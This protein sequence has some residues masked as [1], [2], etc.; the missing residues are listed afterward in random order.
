MIIPGAEASFVFGGGQTEVP[1][2]RALWCSPGEYMPNASLELCP[3]GTFA[4]SS[5]WNR[6]ACVMVPAGFYQNKEGASDFVKCVEELG[7]T[8]AAGS[9]SCNL[10]MIG[11]YRYN[12][13]CELCPEHAECLDGDKFY[14]EPGF[15]Q[16]QPRDGSGSRGASAPDATEIIAC[17]VKDACTGTSANTATDGCALGYSGPLCGVCADDH[18]RST[19]RSCEK[20]HNNNQIVGAAV[21]IIVVPL[22]GGGMIIA[23]RRRL[24]STAAYQ[25]WVMIKR[26]GKVKASTVFFTFQTISQFVHVAHITSFEGHGEEYPNPGRAVAGFL[27]VANLDVVS[28]SPLVC[29]WSRIDFYAVLLMYVQH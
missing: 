15:W 27:G 23:N 2:D 21:A 13:R 24:K 18:F 8:S 25:Y 12:D 7:E 9:E 19:T 11:Y 4:S 6:E 3:K 28:Y 1:A 5:E 10:C 20:C 22:L 14:V 16:A 17:S 26:I 29:L